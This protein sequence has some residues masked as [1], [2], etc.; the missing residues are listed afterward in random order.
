MALGQGYT[1]MTRDLF[2]TMSKTIVA[3]HRYISG[4]M[5][6]E[7]KA[8]HDD[9]MDAL[10][11]KLVTIIRAEAAMADAQI[12]MIDSPDAPAWAK[13]TEHTLWRRDCLED[14]EKDLSG[15]YAP[16]TTTEVKS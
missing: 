4:D 7:S 3:I 12:L 9:D 8:T 11:S 15:F 5:N 10:A 13:D 14:D 16:N 1:D 6:I 2:T